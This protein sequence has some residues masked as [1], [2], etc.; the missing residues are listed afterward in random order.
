VVDGTNF[1]IQ[2]VTTVLISAEGEI[3]VKVDS[4]KCGGQSTG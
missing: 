3:D 1:P 2:I 4:V